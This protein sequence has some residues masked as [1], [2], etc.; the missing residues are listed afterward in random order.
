MS[1]DPDGTIWR[2]SKSDDRKRAKSNGGSLLECDA[3]PMTEA[4][5]NVRFKPE[6]VDADTD[7]RAS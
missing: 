1:V 7:G 4:G 3:S 5:R 6:L 2:F